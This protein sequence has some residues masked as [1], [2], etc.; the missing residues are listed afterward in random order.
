MA[1][2]IVWEDKR[3]KASPVMLG[4]HGNLITDSHIYDE[5]HQGHIFILTGSI[6][7]LDTAES[8]D[9]LVRVGAKELHMQTIK[10]A[11]S[12]KAHGYIYEGTTVTTNG[13]ELFPFCT[14]RVKK[15]VSDAKFYGGSTETSGQVIADNGTLI[16]ETHF[17][18]TTARGMS[19]SD[20]VGVEIILNPNTNYLIKIDN[21]EA[22]DIQV[23]NQMI[24]VEESK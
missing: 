7:D 20:E 4:K 9:V 16:I 10:G 11:V 23:T 19:V 21:E 18:A 8:Y 17:P 12:G 15:S 14:N 22:T 1:Y 13:N 24:W 2:K 3:S 6:D 5:G